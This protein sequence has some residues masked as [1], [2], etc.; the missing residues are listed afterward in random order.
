[1]VDQDGN[2]FEA[3]RPA[4]EA[5]ERAVG[6]RRAPARP[7]PAPPSTRPFWRPRWQGV[8]RLGLA[9][10]LVGF[11]V[12][13]F[14][15]VQERV[16]PVA[17]PVIDRLDPD[18]VIESTGVELMRTAGGEENFVLS[19]PRQQ[20]HENGSTRF[21]GGVNLTV[22]EQADRQSF[23]VTGTDLR[24][25]GAETNFTISGDAQLTVSDGLVVRTGALVYT[26][27]QSLMTMEDGTAG[28]TTISRSGLEASGRN[29]VY[30]RDRA[31]F[32]LPEAVMVRLT[33]DADR[34]AVTIESARA[35][36]AHA[37]RY[38]HFEGGTRVI[39]GSMVL[40][41]ENATAHFGEAETAL[42]RLD[43]RGS[44][45]IYPTESTSGELYELSASD[46]SLTFEETTRTLTRATLSGDA[47]IHSTDPAPGG[48]RRMRAR[49]MTVTFDETSAAVK[50]A[51]LA[52]ESTI[53]L[54]GSAGGRGA[55]ISAATMDVI[56]A[57]DR[58]N[59]TALEAWDNVRLQLPN[60][61]D[62]A[63][64]E[65]RAGRL[66][67]DGPPGAEM[68][69]VRFEQNV[70]YREL[71]TATDTGAEMSRVIR[72]ERLEARVEEGLSALIEARF[73]GDVLFEDGTTRR[74]LA[75]EAVYD[76]LGGSVTLSAGDDAGRTVTLSDAGSDGNDT[77]DVIADVLT[78]SL[79][80]MVAPLLPEPTLPVE[81]APEPTPPVEAAPVEAAPE[82]APIPESIEP[83]PVV[84]RA[85]LI[86]LAGHE[87]S[88]DGS[89][90]EASGNVTSVLTPRSD[91]T[92]ES[93][94]GKMP[95][96]LDDDREVLVSADAVRYDGNAGQTTY[97]GQAHL[98]QDATSFWG[99]TLTLDDRTGNLIAGGNVRTSIQLV[100]LN[101]TTQR[102]EVSLTYAEADTFVYDEAAQ[103]AVYETTARLRS[104]Q[105][106]LK[107][108]TIEVFLETDGRTLDKLQATGNVKLRLDGRWATGES[109][110]YYEAEGRYEMEGAP[111]EIV[112]EV[113]PVETTTTAPPPPGA[114]PPP[115]SCRSS[116]G[117]TLT[118][119]RSTDTVTV[120][121]LEERRTEINGGECTP[122]TF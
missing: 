21:F 42:E 5:Q 103:R 86:A 88:L 90:L 6:G 55:Q 52:G 70:E 115:P 7:E 100:R 48:L 98:W 31:V 107:A 35:T 23:I 111:V 36:L 81:A 57:P 93:V 27:G 121:G 108:D 51:R 84:P 114:I 104:E 82:P 53:E 13:V 33:G 61:P 91:D 58:G 37:D 28:P 40:E 44:A 74:V 59:V 41:S 29:P 49:E 76:V 16:D 69:A 22:T 112:E 9:L 71:G 34:A 39:T 78:V 64:Q 119:Y 72:T 87:V 17:P 63:Q 96:L 95:I 101:E 47:S 43:L 105:V 19:A 83:E 1:M 32:N 25:D 106:D 75:D 68:T 15:A 73:L 18:A 46:M 109:L 65:I 92:P 54:V 67:P 12:V 2:Q 97:T 10:G 26:R 66:S 117:L 94:S 56:M 14:Q 4:I 113:E 45:R 89:M 122:L 85:Y 24:M 80:R 79:I 8:A 3:R 60:T 118:F 116:M 62:G 50:Q 120:D 30:D 38:W 20:T 77:I 99:D 110:V 11:A 102:S